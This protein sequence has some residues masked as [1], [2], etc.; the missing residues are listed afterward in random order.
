MRPG[1][2]AQA[3]VTLVE[4]LVALGIGGLIAVAGFSVLGNAMT[5]QT[6]SDGR[7]ARM[8]EI[9]RA[10][11]ILTLDLEQITAPFGTT[12]D[13][14]L[15]FERTAFA[16]PGA[17][18]DIAYAL[19]DGALLRQIGGTGA[20]TRAQVLLRA[21]RGIDWQV[22]V[23]GRWRALDT[24]DEDAVAKAVRTVIDLA[25]IARG[26][27]GKIARIIVLPRVGA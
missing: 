1:R 13:G 27:S 7:L 2:D 20:E 17:G 4:V 9:E 12:P 11:Q 5:T 25:P 19:K 6:R 23:D 8:A 26:P 3:G 10:M 15:M 14:V 24:A 21:V 22:Y 16:A 18:L